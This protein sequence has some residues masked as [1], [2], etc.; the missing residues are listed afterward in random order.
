MEKLTEKHCVPCEGGVDPLTRDQ[1]EVYLEQLSKWKVI[2]DDKKIERQF[3]FKDF[4]GALEF[5]NKVG[6]IAEEEGHHPDIF[7]HDWNKVRITLWTHAIG[8]LSINDFV[9]A[10]KVDRI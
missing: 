2:E 5:V 7:V 4:P 9:V 10:S 6:A 1:F 8:G 3:E